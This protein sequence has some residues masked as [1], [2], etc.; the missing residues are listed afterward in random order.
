M[1]EV[2]LLGSKLEVPAP[3]PGLVE[4]PRLGRV[5]DTGLQHP[6]TLVNAPPGWGKSVLLSW[7]TRAT[8]LPVG[9]LGVEDGDDPRFWSYLRAALNSAGGHASDALPSPDEAPHEVFLARLAAALA[10]LREPVGVVLDDFH[11]IR[12]P[13]VLKGLEYLAQHAGRALR[14]IIVTRGGPGPPL[15]RLRLAGAVTAL[16]AAELSFTMS[17]TVELL[18]ALGLELPG[19]YTR[20]LHQR[21]EGWPAGLR[22][23]GLSMRGHCDPLRFVDGLTGD[24]E[25]IAG[26]FTSEVLGGLD[27]GHLEVL[28]CG[29]V[30]EQLTG[31]LADALTGRSDGERI[32]AELWDAGAFLDS[33]GG[34][35]S[36]YRCHR[37]LGEF[38]RREL[39]R[40][41]PR[42]VPDL[43]RRAA[44]W[45]AARGSSPDALQ[46]ALLSLDWRMATDL[47]ADHWPDLVLSDSD[48]PL[49]ASDPAPPE[50]AL[51]D[52]P[53]L[54]LACA[55]NQQ[56]L[57]DRRG[58]DRYLR[59]AGDHAAEAGDD[60]ATAIRLTRS[61]TAGDVAATF[62]QASR[63]LAHREDG[64]GARSVAL[65][66]LGTARLA[67]GDLRTAERALHDGLAAAERA[68]L[69]RARAVC[70]SRL[71]VARALLG[72][73]HLAGQT[74]QD[75]LGFARTPAACGYAHLALAITHHEWGDGNEAA[76]YLDLAESPGDRLLAALISIVRLW[77]LQVGE[78]R[79]RADEVLREA[80]HELTGWTVPTYIAHRFTAAE[81]ALRTSF[82]DT[83]TAAR[84]LA[85]QAGASGC[86]APLSVALARIQ[87]R[88]GDLDAAILTAAGAPNGEL[89]LSLEARLLEALAADRLGHDRHVSTTLEKTLQLADHERFRGV[90]LREG[91]AARR[92]LSAHLDSG[93]ACWPFVMEIVGCAAERTD[94]PAAPLT[95]RELTVLRYLQSVLTTEEIAAELHL[96]VNTVKTHTRHIYRKLTASR[97]REAVRKARE[98]QL[99]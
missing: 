64:E 43:H 28:L 71:A 93:T 13:R 22:L 95:E 78:H 52:N 33:V 45:Y 34:R 40:R 54:A 84:L 89:G 2:P 83:G 30:L 38:L 74:A 49:W 32:L 23:A 8:D 92:L 67:T 3:P 47:L 55:L 7:W 44:A 12:D 99:L 37:L 4:R 14:M 73:L 26:Y 79:S 53:D 50:A 82:G 5:L 96:S 27:G 72:E 68:G 75:S 24:H 57:G 42:R 25:T 20:L 63:L 16:E 91:P 11:R 60:K 6:L 29:S 39:T 62:S 15:A 70:L 87:L 48:P 61:V 66:A 1:T 77:S 65:S 41:A 98:A 35:R 80:H 9:W 59:L 17:E 51:R 69:D 81:A 90:F 56:L 76:R 86:S 36:S 31:S 21:T 18:A 46:H 10:D 94:G 88:D 19:R 85:D 58:T 97:R